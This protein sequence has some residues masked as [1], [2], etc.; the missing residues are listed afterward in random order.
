LIAGPTD[1]RQANATFSGVSGALR[2]TA[3]RTGG[4]SWWTGI[5]F[6]LQ[7]FDSS[8]D[9]VIGPLNY[10]IFRVSRRGSSRGDRGR[11]VEVLGSDATCD[12]RIG[13]AFNEFDREIGERFGALLEVVGFAH[14]PK[15]RQV[16]SR[17]R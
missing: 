16:E 13:Q 12:D 4:I 5:I 8:I 9:R 3:E 14:A 1:A 15:L 7:I 2:R 11:R 6:N 17:P 10:L